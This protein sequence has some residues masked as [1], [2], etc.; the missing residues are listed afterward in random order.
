MPGKKYQAALAL[1]EDGKFYTLADA[2]TLLKK[3]AF[4]KFDET[5]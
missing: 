1:V 3:I 5:V 4:A 2:V